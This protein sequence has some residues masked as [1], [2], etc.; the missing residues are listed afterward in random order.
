MLMA[1]AKAPKKT[2]L[3]ALLA[4]AFGG[5]GFF[6]FG[7]RQGLRATFAWLVAALLVLLIPSH[8]SA[9]FDPQTVG[10]FLLQAGLAWF[11]YRMCKRKNAEAAKAADST[12]PGAARTY[13]VAPM[14][15]R[16]LQP[17]P[18]QR[19]SKKLKDIGVFV[20][21]GSGFALLMGAIHFNM[22]PM[23]EIGNFAHY[24]SPYVCYMGA[25]GLATGIGLL[26]AQRWAR[27]SMLVFS[28]LLAAYGAVGVVVFLFM[29][30][31]DM[32]GWP[33]L[34]LKTG[35]SIYWLFHVAIGVWW[36]TYFNRNNVKAYFRTPRRAPL[37]SA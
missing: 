21:V 4:F 26:R 2:W 16:N 7:L 19:C 29:P 31:G 30:N 28:S 6:Y 18:E 34:L 35:V 20:I 37:V 9:S 27:I 24:I 17:T 33:L 23:G 10:L 13:G 15:N 11:A 36:L 12:D 32:S 3:A 8:P 5:P 25:W 14:M 22:L 1:I